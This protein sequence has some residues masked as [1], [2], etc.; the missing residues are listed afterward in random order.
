[1]KTVLKIF[2][3]C[4]LPAVSM[5]QIDPTWGYVTVQQADSLKRSEQTEQND[6][7]KMAA[8]RSLGF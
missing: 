2:L 5:A 4:L 1:M 7:L 3:L 8:Y 6:T